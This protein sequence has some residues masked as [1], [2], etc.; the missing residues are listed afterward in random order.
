MEAVAACMNAVAVSRENIA[1][2][3]EELGADRDRH[4]AMCI[5]AIHACTHVRSD[6]PIRFGPANLTAHMHTCGLPDGR[7]H[8]HAIRNKSLVPM[9]NWTT[10]H[11]D[12]RARRL[13]GG[14]EPES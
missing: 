5:Q 11:V 1:R 6:R 14:G 4:I 2:G 8:L 13:R 3:F 9:P 7:V 12:R 10:I